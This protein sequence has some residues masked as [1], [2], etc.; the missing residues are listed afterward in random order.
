MDDPNPYASPKAEVDESG[1]TIEG[2]ATIRREGKYLFAPLGA[3]FPTRCVSCNAPTQHILKVDVVKQN[4]ENLSART[5]LLSVGAAVLF[6]VVLFLAID[7]RGPDWPGWV[8]LAWPISLVCIVVLYS[9][10]H[11]QR[12]RF[13]VC[14][15]HRLLRMLTSLLTWVPIAL[16]WIV[17]PE[18]LE[19][20]G[21]PAE[22]V[23]P[24]F[25]FRVLVPFVIIVIFSSYLSTWNRVQIVGEKL[26][27]DR[28]RF[29]GFGKKYLDSFP[30]SETTSN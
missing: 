27:D 18:F 1:Y 28:F 5:V 20:I 16:I 7:V 22:Q 13:Y 14:S 26:S 23:E 17:Q 4:W 19:N 9:R 3:Q 21:I 30:A 8:F 24:F 11:S 2:D 12:F 15:V 6:F 25:E 10:W 29:Q